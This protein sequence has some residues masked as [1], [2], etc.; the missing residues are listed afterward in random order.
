[1][2]TLVLD[3]NELA[4]DFACVSLR[5]QLLAHTGGN[6]WIEVVVPAVVFEETVANY[7]RALRK[8]QCSPV[9]DDRESRR[10]GLHVEEPMDN[11]TYREYLAER[12]D[13]HLGISVL[14]WPSVS[15]AQLVD[16][17]VRRTKP[18]NSSGGGYRDALVWA[19]VV[20]LAGNG[21]DVVLVS[22]DK[23]AF[24][25]TDGHLS[26]PLSSEL[27][28]LRGSVELVPELGPWLLKAL[29]WT[30]NDLVAAVVLAQD[31]QIFED[32]LTSD[33]QSYWE[34][35]VTDIGFEASP[36]ATSFDAQ[37]DGTFIRKATSAGPR[38]VFIAEYEL[39]FTLVV[40]A[41]FNM[42]NV[43]E[44]SWMTLVADYYG[45]KTFEGEVA[46]VM[47]MTVLF[48]GDFLFS[49]E[50]EVW[51]R[52]DGVGKGACS[53]SPEINP[54]QLALFEVVP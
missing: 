21:R 12:F 19:D 8:A 44:I 31:E 11:L 50:D 39:D 38:G 26:D 46:M 16:R 6:P 49:I 42:L 37:W 25:G 2:K 30:P 14:P 27:V 28:E 53:Y 52:T 54:D 33:I 18:F 35:E 5:Y 34:P 20:A 4:R 29:P 24:A 15:H 45:Q 22:S 32:L 1:M 13:E 51:R 23:K 48:G 43:H 9:I 47:R 10:L 41:T 40:S 17:A 36:C 3:S 7:G